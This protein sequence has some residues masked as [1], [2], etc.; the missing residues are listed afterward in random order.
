MHLLFSLNIH[1]HSVLRGLQDF[2]I[3][4]NFPPR[5]ATSVL[6]LKFNYQEWKK[7]IMP[8]STEG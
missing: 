2:S 5:A 7:L 6:N 1:Y 8:D 3:Q 4:D